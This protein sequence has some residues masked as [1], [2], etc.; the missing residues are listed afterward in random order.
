[1]PREKKTQII[2][3]LQQVFSESR[4][5][6]FTDYRGLS[7]AEITELRR[8]LR[9]SGVKYRVVKN[10]MARFAVEK[11]GKSELVDFFKGPVAIV[12][13]EGDAIGPAKALV[14]FIRTSKS[15]L[16]I[17]GGF[18]LDRILTSSDVETLATLPPRE[19]LLGRVLAG[20]QSPIVALVSCLA[21]PIRG[22]TGVLQARIKQLEGA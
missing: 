8:A 3:E 17:K 19:I 6:I 4:V 5:G 18:L 11:A 20:M 15:S 9:K 10:T 2:D 16:S 7:T 14:E 12:F 1:M 13:G 22:V 21:G